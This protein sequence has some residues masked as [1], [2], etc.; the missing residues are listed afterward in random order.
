MKPIAIFAAGLPGETAGINVPPP[1]ED[2]PNDQPPSLAA[3]PADPVL[4]GASP[5]RAAPP[6]TSHC[7][8]PDSV[9]AKVA[10]MLVDRGRNPRKS[11]PSHWEDRFIP[12]RVLPS[13]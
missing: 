6:K 2:C 13:T 11:D 12:K 8:V 7:V 9:V 3:T 10:R 1:L 4:A 5:S